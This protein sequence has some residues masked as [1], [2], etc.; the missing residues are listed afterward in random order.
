[1]TIIRERWI[2]SHKTYFEKEVET[3]LTI[4]NDS[5]HN[6]DDIFIVCERFMPALKILNSNNKELVLYTN[7]DMRQFLKRRTDDT[8]AKLLDGLNKRE[9]YMLWI[10]LPNELKVGESEIIKL[11]YR[12][13]QVIKNAYSKSRMYSIPKFIYSY[14]F[15]E[16]KGTMHETFY[17]VSAPEDN[18]IEYEIKKITV[19]EGNVHRTLTDKDGLHQNNYGHSISI[20]IPP[21]I[22][23]V[24]FEIN[25]YIKPNS[26]EVKFIIF[27]IITLIAFS[28]IV[29]LISTKIV[30]D[31][32]IPIFT[33]KTYDNHLFG[34]IF[35][36]SFAA[37]GLIRKPI[38]YITRWWFLVPIGISI[39]GFIFQ[40]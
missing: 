19:L 25:Y 15:A 33:I 4:L 20:R 11:K 39:F 31:P 35:T 2:I 14:K 38:M 21:L 18:T 24:N 7:E 36:I 3:E 12:D 40:R 22:N 6:Y 28:T 32:F 30:D 10:K 9:Y 34:F 5:E 27:A 17:I 23:E 16:G 37:M 26:H 1:M 8:A 29:S 13:N